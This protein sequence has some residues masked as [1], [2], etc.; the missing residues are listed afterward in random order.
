MTREQTVILVVLGILLAL[1]IIVS[2]TLNHY[3]GGFLQTVAR[4][5]EEQSAA[6]A[7][8]RAGGRKQENDS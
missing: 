2:A 7:E 4:E 5:E 6:R 8:A 3:I 1:C